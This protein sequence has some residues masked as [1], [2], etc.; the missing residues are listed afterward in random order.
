MSEQV[1]ATAADGVDEADVVEVVGLFEN[2][3]TFD[4][5]VEALLTGGFQR[6]AISVLASHTSLEASA[7]N[8]AAPQDDALTALV[9]E[10]SYAFPLESAGLL[11]VVGGPISG[12]IGALMAAGIGGMALKEYLDELT[13]H[14]DTDAF[15]K[16][17]EEGGLVIWV[18]VADDAE[19]AKA[20]EILT[21]EGAV[22]VHLSRRVE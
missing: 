17:L 9:G 8:P 22:N 1:E 16:A 4:C 19:E 12:S 18:Q 14:P 15:A 20:G 13:S 5:A 21:A 3:H 2:R 11:T 7:P 6:T 10:L